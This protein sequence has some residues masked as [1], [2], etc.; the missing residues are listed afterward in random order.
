MRR[1]A[2]R[3][4]T[5]ATVATALVLGSP[6]AAQAA[7]YPSD[8]TEPDLVS[9]LNGYDQ[10]WTS[11]GGNDLH[12]TVNDPATLAKNDQLTSWINQHATTAQQFRALQDAEYD[13]TA[14]TAYDQS[15]TVSQG[16]GA[17]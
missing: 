5:V 17:D 11:S 16:L 3:G 14:R 12:G 9:L 2:V 15:F 8:S 10:Y 6:L 4:V 7:T 1:S 13:N